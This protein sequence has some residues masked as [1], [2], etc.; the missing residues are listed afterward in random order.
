MKLVRRIAC[1]TKIFGFQG[2]QG[3]WITTKKANVGAISS[4][5]GDAVYE[6]IAYG[7]GYQLIKLLSANHDENT[8][9]K[10]LGMLFA[11]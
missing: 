6:M 3:T 1:F 5:S 2:V 4:V 9:H 10:F 7:V 8:L 11:I